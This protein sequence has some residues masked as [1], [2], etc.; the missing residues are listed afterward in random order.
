MH[1]YGPARE[2]GKVVVK[3]PKEAIEES[4]SKWSPSLVGQ[5]L[6]KPFPFVRAINDALD[7][8]PFASALNPDCVIERIELL[9]NFCSFNEVFWLFPGCFSFV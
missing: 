5:F 1:Y 2:D 3:P 9:I 6:N 7:L 4:I 8:R